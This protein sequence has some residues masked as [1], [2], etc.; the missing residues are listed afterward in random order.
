LNAG[1]DPKPR[2]RISLSARV[3]P[4]LE[5]VEEVKPPRVSRK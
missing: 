3:A 2:L 5:V 1:R 4:P